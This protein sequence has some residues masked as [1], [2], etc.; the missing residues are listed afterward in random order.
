MAKDNIRRIIAFPEIEEFYDMLMD[1]FHMVLADYFLKDRFT[2]FLNVIP[3]DHEE[4]TA[5]Y[6]DRFEDVYLIYG[7]LKMQKKLLEKTIEEKPE[8]DEYWRE[9]TKVKKL[10]KDQT[11]VSYTVFYELRRGDYTLK[12][13]E[14]IGVG[15]LNDYFH[16]ILYPEKNLPPLTN[17]QVSE[18]HILKTYFDINEYRYLSLPLIQFSEFDGVVHVILSSEDY[19]DSFLKDGHRFNLKSVGNLIKSFSREY[20]ELILNWDM[21]GGARM[22]EEAFIDALSTDLFYTENNNPILMELGYHEYYSRHIEY[23]QNKIA[24]GKKIPRIVRNEYR[25]SAIMHILIDSYAHNISAHSLIALEWIFKLRAAENLENNQVISDVKKLEVSHKFTP[26][27]ERNISA[28]LDTEISHL[29]RFLL[30]K[31]A[32]WSGLT[33]NISFGGQSQNLFY[34]FWNKFLSN[35]LYL[36]TIAFTENISKINFNFTF[37]TPT[38]NVQNIKFKKRILLDGH[39]VT[40]DLSKFASNLDVENNNHFVTKGTDFNRISDA[41]SKCIV[42]M[43]G[44]IVGEHAFFTILETELRNVKHYSTE[45]LKEISI[46]GLTL[47]ISIEEHDISNDGKLEVTPYYKIG[48][49]LKHIIH[50][51][52]EL[53]LLRPIRLY[54]DI[55]DENTL[56]PKLGGTFQ[57]KVCAAMLLNNTFSSVENK[58]R[59]RDRR[60]YPWIK[61]GSMLD[62]RYAKGDIIEEYEISARRVLSD[63]FPQSKAYFQKQFEPHWGYLV[64]YFHIWKGEVLFQLNTNIES[65]GILDNASRFKC[66]FI[67]PDNIMLLTRIREQGV[68]RVIHS[69]VSNESEAYIAWLNKWLNYREKYLIEFSVEGNVVAQLELS[70]F[71]ILFRSA[72]NSNLQKDIIPQLELNLAHRIEQVDNIGN[73]Y[74]RYRSHGVFIQYFCGNKRLNELSYMEPIIVAELMEVLATKICFF[75]NRIK[76]RVQNVNEKILQNQSNCT[77]YSEDYQDW[78]LEKEKGFFNYHFLVVHLSFIEAFLDEMGKRK[79]DEND[80]KRFIDEEI[81][82]GQDIPD[83]FILVITTGRGRTQWWEKLKSWSSIDI[84]LGASSVPPY[85]TFVT[86]RPVESILSAIENAL[87]ISDDIELK[88]RLVKELFGS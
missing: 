16:P 70:D 10:D 11:K 35:S 68:I 59:E 85:T 69:T 39:F 66:V 46:H 84:K 5:V 9:L 58:D 52:K 29:M 82:D 47:N 50:I 33:R 60:F 80:I 53:L 78:K 54:S 13:I 83:N 81:I 28:P 74:I 38:N 71:D 88:Y 24:Y 64:K 75:D 23:F 7:G 2:V 55:I 41:L 20:E 73:D 31:G 44:G 12:D 22:R 62:N 34:L 67:P 30:E 49:Y 57:D 4:G 15:D 63:D 72:T 36:G 45:E 3:R 87:M 56:L 37:L 32:F 8:L 65:Y 51:D 61:V 19:Q 48:V 17:V 77:F 27:V 79:Y 43:P 25:Q 76:M 26:L 18:Y 40:I 21:S 1:R 6:M 86:F 42:Y 14:H